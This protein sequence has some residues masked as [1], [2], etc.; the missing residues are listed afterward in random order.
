MNFGCV[1]SLPEKLM[2][3]MMNIMMLVM[4]MMMMKAEVEGERLKTE[5][6]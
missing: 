1:E 4:M 3:T 5:D 6:E 2:M